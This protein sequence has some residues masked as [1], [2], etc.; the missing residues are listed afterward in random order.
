MSFE[1]RLCKLEREFNHLVNVMGTQRESVSKALQGVQTTM[2]EQELML[3]TH[4]GGML[5]ALK[6]LAQRQAEQEEWRTKIEER[7]SRL[8]K[9]PPAA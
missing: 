8:E 9:R 5:E 1:D 4:L 6:E 2:L 7:V 3:R